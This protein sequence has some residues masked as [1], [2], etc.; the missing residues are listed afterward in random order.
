MLGPLSVTEGLAVLRPGGVPILRSYGLTESPILTVRVIG[1][2]T[3][4]APD[5]ATYLKDLTAYQGL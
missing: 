3:P 5:S 2:R 1:A 4:Y